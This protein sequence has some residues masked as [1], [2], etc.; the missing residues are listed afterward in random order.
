MFEA[1]SR[2]AAVLVNKNDTCLLE[3]STELRA[4]II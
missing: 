2:A 3:R 4:D 1:Y